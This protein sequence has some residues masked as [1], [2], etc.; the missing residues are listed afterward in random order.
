M[1]VVRSVDAV[2]YQE[3]SVV[4]VGTYDGVHLGHQAIIR[5]LTERAKA[6][7]GRSVVIT[8]EPHPREV[9][10]RGPVKRLTTPDERL[11]LLDRMHVDLVFVLEF[12]YEF[13]RQS[14]RAF[15]ERYVID[16]IGLKE[17]IV[18]YDHMFGRDR[19]AGV[20]ELQAMG[21]EHGFTEHTVA[22]PWPGHPAP[23]GCG[24]HR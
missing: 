6:V 18:G 2:D 13:S 22:R 10:G 14:S 17:V 19:E 8:F 5:A 21:L 11:A 12:T 23:G 7:G 15:Y 9:V 16:A 1:Q 4:T 24:P 20:K 3:R